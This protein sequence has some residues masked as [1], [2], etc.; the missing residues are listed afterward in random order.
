MNFT[1][2]QYDDPAWQPLQYPEVGSQPGAEGMC[3]GDVEDT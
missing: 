1:P 3:I 2:Q